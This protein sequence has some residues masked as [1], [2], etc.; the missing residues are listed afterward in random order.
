MGLASGI[1]LDVN[2]PHKVQ[3]HVLVTM[4]VGSG[5]EEGAKMLGSDTAKTPQDIRLPDHI[6]IDIGLHLL[7]CLPS[8]ERR[9]VPPVA[10]EMLKQVDNRLLVVFVEAEGYSIGFLSVAVSAAALLPIP[11]FT[12]FEVA[13]E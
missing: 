4:C 13:A 10:V 1:M 11:E 8:I 6:C 5:F 9:S 3:E 7:R 12:D 2:V